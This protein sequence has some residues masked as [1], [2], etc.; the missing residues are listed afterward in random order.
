MV[1]SF[2]WPRPVTVPG[3]QSFRATEVTPPPA[4][5]LMERR[6]F[7]LIEESC[8]LAASRYS[9][10]DG[11]CYAIHDVDDTYESRSMRGLFYAMGGSDRMLEIAYRSWE[12]TTALYSDGVA[13]RPD[14]PAF[15]NPRFRPQ[16]HNEYYTDAGPY[17]WFHMGEGN[18]SFYDFGLADPTNPQMHARARRFAG[19]Y[20]GEDASAPNWDPVH[21]IIRSTF[22]GSLGPK[23]KMEPDRTRLYLDPV[24]GKP[25]QNRGYAQRTNLHPV[26]KDLDNNWFDDPARREEVCRLFDEIILNGDVPDNLICTALI[27]NA[28]LYTGDDKYKKWV[29]DYTEVWLER[30]RANG[31]IIPDNVGPTGKTG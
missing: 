31:G 16:L 21:K 10:P 20:L 13:R 12:S 24:Y 25:E 15:T 1:A 22:H 27:T 9:R 29:L 3:I 8:E 5:A 4:W 14:D 19:L 11:N 26:I 23:F 18:Q 2:S 17:D 7:K 30:A 6:L 28:Y